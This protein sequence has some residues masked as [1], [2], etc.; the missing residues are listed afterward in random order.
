MSFYNYVEGRKRILN[1]LDSKTNIQA[2]ETIPKSD[3]EFTYENGIR[4][5]VGALFVDI[6]NSSEYF[7]QNKPDIVARVMRAFCSEIIT[8]LSANDAYRQ[9]GIRGDCVYA[10]YSCPLKDDIDSIF[11]DAAQINTFRKMFSTIL[12]N[13]GFPSINFGIG[14]GTNQDLIIKAGKKGSGISDLIWI[15]DAVI[16]ASNL[17]GLANKGSYQP[18][19][20]SSCFYENIKDIKPTEAH[21]Y[22]DWITKQYSPEL[23]QAV[24]HCD[25]VISDFNEWIQEKLQ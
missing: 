3:E 18:I 20:M 24:Y 4:S 14:L 17:S 9:I 7:T 11:T 12:E 8:I 6:R 15:G 21:T 25:I 13:K 2:S 10:I 5:W 22:K 16:D 19:V 1:I 23:K